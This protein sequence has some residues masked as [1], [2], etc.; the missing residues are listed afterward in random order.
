MTKMLIAVRVSVFALFAP[1]MSAMDASANVPAGVCHL[2][3]YEMSDGS[4]TVVQPSVNDDLRYR[5]ENGVTGRLYYINDNEYESGEGW[6]V[7]EPVTLRVTFGDCET[8]I[9]R[10][11]RK[12]AP[13]LTG[14]QIPL[15]VKPVSF[16]SNGE[17]LY[18]ELVLPVQRKPRAAVVLQYGGGRDSAVIN[19][20]VQYLLPLHDIAVFVFDKRGTG[21]S[22][23]EFNAHIPMLAD[24]TVAAIEAVVIC[25][26]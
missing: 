6:A 4:R 10:F 3:A 9:V 7:R 5:F 2:G 25:R 22:G 14:E 16:R 11:D 15:P 23:G 17:T 19:N 1:V 24:D 8:G 13:A 21:R 12:G 26:K 18:G 20:Y